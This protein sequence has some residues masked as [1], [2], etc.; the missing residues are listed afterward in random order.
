MWLK[1]S[2]KE[3]KIAFLL[4][5]SSG[6][7][8]RY[9]LRDELGVGEG[10]LKGLYEELKR[11][12]LIEVHRGGARISIKGREALALMLR[13]CGVM[14]ARIL[15]EVN[16][17]GE[18]LRGVAAALTGDVKNVVKARDVVVRAGA[19]MALIVKV[20]DGHMYLPAVEDYNIKEYLPDVYGILASMPRTTVYV[21]ALSE[22]IYPCI[23]G[24]LRL[25][26]LVS[27]SSV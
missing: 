7:K 10:I 27:K 3:L 26:E 13:E 18:R 6:V 11:E 22:K 14:D 5:L 23:L 12:G 9:T 24:I 8:G 17:W 20:K 21:V 4:T 1:V 25:G 19:V 16:A 15:E 2:R